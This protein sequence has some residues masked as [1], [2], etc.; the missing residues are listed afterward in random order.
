MPGS[1]IRYT[2]HFAGRVQGVGFRYRTMEIARRHDVSGIVE[3]LSDGRVR[4]IAEGAPEALDAFLTELGRQ[5]AA[6][7]HQR[8]L[9]EDPATGEFGQPG[10]DPLTIR[11]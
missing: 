1:M 5:M 8:Q 6:N 7:I 9:H 4:L 3:N 2:V 10:I 11:R